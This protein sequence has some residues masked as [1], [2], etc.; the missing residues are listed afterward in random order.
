MLSMLVIGFVLSAGVS[1]TARRLRAL[2]ADGAA[3]AI[4]VGTLIYGFGGWRPAALLVLFFATSSTLT[5]LRAQYKPHPE[6]RRG[7]S[8]DQVLA[9]GAVA[10]VM[11][12]WYGLTLSPVA[13][14]AVAGAIA[15]STAD[16][17]ATELGLLSPSPPRLIT[18]WQTVPPGQS[19]AIS[20]L[21]TAGG[22]AGALLIGAVGSWWVHT[23]FGVVW[24][25]GV[26][27]MLIDSLM[28]A[29]VEGR[30]EGVNNNTINLIATAT[31][32]LIAVLR[33]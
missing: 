10:T 11:A 9:N 21:G 26:A 31:G 5:R 25:A 32:T 7:R 20:L 14:A 13:A 6:H 22:I 17:W 33:S 15:A 30:V 29:T 1:L 4:V 18:T 2:T 23:S 8:A 12:I 3:A 16:T 24:I 28:G 19:G 27:A